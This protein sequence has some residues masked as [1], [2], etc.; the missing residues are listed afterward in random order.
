MTGAYERGLRDEYYEHGG[1]ALRIPASGAGTDYKLPDVFG[2]PVKAGG[3]LEDP[4]ISTSLHAHELKRTSKGDSV[5]FSVE[6]I[7]DLIQ[8]SEDWGAIP[9]CTVFFPYTGGYHCAIPTREYMETVDAKTFG[10]KKEDVEKMTNLEG[11]IASE[12][13]DDI[14][15]VS[16]I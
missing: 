6:E 5:R 7:F 8:F 2:R 9:F 4:S 16:D 1:T 13:L 15:R 10:I 3:L 12:N 11:L 14:A